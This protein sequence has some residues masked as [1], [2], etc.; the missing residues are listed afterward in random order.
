MAALLLHKIW[1]GLL[2]GKPISVR[3][4]LTHK[5]SVRPRAIPLNSASALERATTFRFLLFQVTRF[6]PTRVK[7]PE[8][9][10]WSR[11]SPAQSESV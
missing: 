2:G 11:L 4:L 3:S 1:M 9:D 7:Y 10:L 6:P 8:V 5:I